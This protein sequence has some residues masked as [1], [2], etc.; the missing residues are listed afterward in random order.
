MVC[1][2]RDNICKWHRYMSGDHLLDVLY[3][4]QFFNFLFSIFNVCPKVD[5]VSIYGSD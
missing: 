2:D 1:L 4:I 5:F 3:Y